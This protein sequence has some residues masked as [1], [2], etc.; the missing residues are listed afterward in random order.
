M[1]INATLV[2]WFIMLV[3]VVA[4][5]VP[6]PVGW[7]KLLVWGVLVLATIVVILLHGGT[8]ALK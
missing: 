7:G 1:T 5:L 3:L 4:H 8:F 2:L 6:K